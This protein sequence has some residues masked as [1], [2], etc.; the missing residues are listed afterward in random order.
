MKKLLVQ[1]DKLELEEHV[2]LLL[3]G[4]GTGMIFALMGNLIISISDWRYVAYEKARIIENA[5]HH[6]TI[7]ATR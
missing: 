4:C 2:W 5:P 7:L 3:F 1:L 6:D